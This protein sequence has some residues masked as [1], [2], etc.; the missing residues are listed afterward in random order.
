[1]LLFFEATEKRTHDDILEHIK[2]KMRKH[3]MNLIFTQFREDFV[4]LIE[5]KP[6]S[7]KDIQSFFKENYPNMKFSDPDNLS[8]YF[9]IC[10]SNTEH[11]PEIAIEDN[12]IYLKTKKQIHCLPFNHFVFVPKPSADFIFFKTNAYLGNKPKFSDI[13][14]DFVKWLEDDALFL[15]YLSHKFETNN[16]ESLLNN[17][18]QIIFKGAN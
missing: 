8:H 1:M 4:N 5:S 3:I 7:S 15:N 6:K 10:F 16:V 14:K 12:G 2:D 9:Y 17:D 18:N 13:Y 11:R